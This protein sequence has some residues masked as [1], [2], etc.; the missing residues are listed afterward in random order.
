VLRARRVFDCLVLREL[1][2]TET[3]YNLILR[4]TVWYPSLIVNR[5][6]DPGYVVIPDMVSNKCSKNRNFYFKISTKAH[7]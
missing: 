3:H 2:K 5:D 6:P 1:L 7:V 4:R